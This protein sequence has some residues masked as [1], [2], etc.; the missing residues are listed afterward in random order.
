MLQLS[1]ATTWP[2][3]AQPHHCTPGTPP[4]AEP[5]A[6]PG[7]RP[8]PAGSTQLQ[9]CLG[10]APCCCFLI[11]RPCSDPSRKANPR[12]SA[13]PK[14]SPTHPA[15]CAFLFAPGGVPAKPGP[16]MEPAARAEVLE[17]SD[18]L[19]H[20]A[21]HRGRGSGNAPNPKAVPSR[22]SWPQLGLS[23]LPPALQGEASPVWQEL[24]DPNPLVQAGL[25]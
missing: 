17:V 14:P 5:P 15:G 2:G 22:G 10:S 6:A 21:P 11:P 18:L 12:G 16:G 23:P 1:G 8:Q 24:R 13:C 19:W 4:G 25:H 9:P 7:V 3:T 20:S